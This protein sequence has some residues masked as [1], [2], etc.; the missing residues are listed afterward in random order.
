M[1]DVNLPNK[2]KRRR[3]NRK[4]IDAVKNELKEIELLEDNVR[5]RQ[6]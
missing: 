6:K 3:P 5:D 1:R 4:F 2:K